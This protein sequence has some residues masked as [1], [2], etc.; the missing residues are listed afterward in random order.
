MRHRSK[1]VGAA[2]EATVL[3]VWAAKNA[4]NLLDST[5]AHQINYFP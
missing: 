1:A 3:L 2:R 4:P 5:A